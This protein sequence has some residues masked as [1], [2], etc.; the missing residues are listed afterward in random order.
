MYCAK[1]AELI[2]MPFE[3]VTHV[4]PRNHVLDKGQDQTNPFSA[5]SDDKSAMRPFAKLLWTLFWL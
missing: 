3:A 1:M 2:E 5:I 4:G